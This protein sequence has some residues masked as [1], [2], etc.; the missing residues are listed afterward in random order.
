MPQQRVKLLKVTA[1][2]S[3]SPPRQKLAAAIARRDEL[4]I[5]IGAM[6]SAQESM[7][8]DAA[9]MAKEL[10]DAAAAIESAE[11]L[12]VANQVELRL[13]HEP[14]PGPTPDQARERVRVLADAYET[15]QRARQ[16]LESQRRGIEKEMEL[17]DSEVRKTLSAAAQSDLRINAICGR[18]FACRREQVELMRILQVIAKHGGI[19]T[20]YATWDHQILADYDF[21]ELTEW[22]AW[23]KAFVNLSNDAAVEFPP[24]S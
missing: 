4:R 20:P 6:K 14:K 21:P 13:G 1:A 23:E 7:M 9:P 5:R 2:H 19:P 17:A 10:E 12:A 15:H 22:K 18:Y 24:A 16:H 8:F 11:E 3:L